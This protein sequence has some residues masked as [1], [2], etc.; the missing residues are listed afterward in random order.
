MSVR[1][2][3]GARLARIVHLVSI[4][5]LLLATAGALLGPG[6]R[7]PDVFF[8]ILT[9]VV[10]GGFSTLGRLIV[11][12]AGN[13]IGWV[14]LGMAAAA[15]LTL[16]ATA[17]IEAAFEVPYRP[18]LPGTEYAAWVVNLGPALIA[19]GIPMLFLLFPTG[20]PPNRRW[21][22]VG[23]V[24]LAGVTLSA[25]WLMFRPGEIYGERDLYHFDNPFGFSFIEP[26]RF[27]FFDIGSACIVV[28][29]VASIVSLVVRFRRA[30]G[31]ER[32]Q[33]KWLMLVGVAGLILFLS[34]IIAGAVGPEGDKGV[35][36]VLWSI[37][38]V[39][40]IVGIPGATALAIF[41]YRLYAVDVVISKT[42]VFAGLALFIAA[43]YVAI[44][45]GIGALLGGDR[46][47]TA[48]RIAATA[49]VAVAFEPARQR[50]Q[51]LANRLVYGKRATPYEV[52]ASFGHRMAVV[53]SVD[54]VLPSM[55]ETAA[56]GVGATAARVMVQLGDGT[57]RSVSWPQ[58]EVIDDPTFELPV[59]H[60]DQL[61]GAIAIVKPPNEPLRPGE[62][63]LLEDLARNA[64]LA[65]HNVRL[66]SDLGAKA[67]ELVV[68]T[69]E[70]ERSRERLVTARDT[71]RRR[72]ERELRDGV[73]TQLGAIRDEIGSDA[74]RVE[75]EPEVVE[76]SLDDLGARATAAL[77]ELRDVARGIFPPLLSDKGLG[78]ALEALVRKTGASVT[79]VLDP[80]AD[81][82]Y[83][84]AVENAVYFCCVQALQNA[85]RHAPSADGRG[86][87][88]IR[89]R[90][91]PVR[92]P[93]RRSGV[94]DLDDGCGRGDADHAGPDRS[95]RGRARDR[96][97]SGPWHHR[98]GARARSSD[99]GVPGMTQ[100]TAK[101]VSTSILVA[102]IAALGALTTL[103]LVGGERISNPG[104]AVVGDP[105]TPGFAQV[106][107]DL[108]AQLRRGQAARLGAGRD[109][110][111]H[112]DPRRGLGRDGVAHRVAA[113]AEHR[114]LAL[115]HRRRH[116]RG[117]RA[118]DRV[119][120]LRRPAGLEP[121]AGPGAGRARRRLLLPR[122]R[123]DPAPR[124]VVPRRASAQ[125]PMA[126][127]GLGLARRHRRRRRSRTRSRP[128]R[129]TASSSTGSCTR[130]RS[131]SARSPRVARAT[132]SSASARS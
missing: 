105:D 108:E 84:P 52:M 49:G 51:H 64:G 10:I 13:V 29:A 39:V 9:L 69:A 87:S 68:Q 98:N 54:D 100:R 11:T 125:R 131:G 111:D 104:I 26:L 85:E 53:P 57:E 99:G 28:A 38:V 58:G 101:I 24:W 34:L 31:E 95:A 2:I 14:F 17:Y 117:R 128:A 4:G 47:G 94:R 109:R 124:A 88:R 106:R 48:L 61:I 22:W 90:G 44:V 97:H 123:A 93:R 55:A 60:G 103:R 127:G 132:P 77:D 42:I 79:F 46:S 121:A 73:G 74:E 18:S 115:L 7:G 72:L 5:I 110:R 71:Q 30:R 119:H 43:A 56:R 6:E 116:H 89:R 19:M 122:R 21:R 59:G 118:R 63:V 96:E 113:A 91:D 35:D 3:R 45:V 129:S 1:T 86:P 25:V 78:A 15:T 12:R 37:L 66:A 112:R 20:S 83:E 65:L 41:R 76:E 16:P 75:T 126:M 8:G 70:I 82:R 102:I 130:T 23:W 27:L 114:R 32:Q 120:D 107:S 33:L 50:L 67:E 62:R 40:L 80:A 81:R 92:D 36:D